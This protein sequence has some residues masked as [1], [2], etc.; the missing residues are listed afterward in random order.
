MTLGYMPKRLQSIL[1]MSNKAK[2]P[3]FKSDIQKVYMHYSDTINFL[4]LTQ[5]GMTR[6][7]YHNRHGQFPIF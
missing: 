5:T 1:H 2:R 6:G 4:F 3:L 7:Q